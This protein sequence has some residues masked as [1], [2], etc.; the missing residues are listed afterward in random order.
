MEY[1][2]INPAAWLT[3]NAEKMLATV[4][5]TETGAVAEVA[6]TDTVNIVLNNRLY[7]KDAIVALMQGSGYNLQREAFYEADEDLPASITLIF[8][9]A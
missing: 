8:K 1:N 3:A 4:I 9:G 6:I 7:K 2:P 5:K